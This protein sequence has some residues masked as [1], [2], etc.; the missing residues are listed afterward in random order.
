MKKRNPGAIKRGERANLCYG[1][2]GAQ[3]VRIEPLRETLHPAVS[4]CL[5]VSPAADTSYTLIADDGKGHST[6]Q[7]FELRVAH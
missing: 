1:V 2:Y 6:R 4:H 5:R 7:T 3:S